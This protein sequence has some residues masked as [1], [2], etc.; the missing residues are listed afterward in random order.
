MGQDWYERC[1]R[2][3]GGYLKHWNST[4]EGE[5]GEVAFTRWLREAIPGHPRVLDAGCGDG[6]YTLH[7]AALAEQ[8]AG[9]DFAP[10]MIEA[11][12]RN[13]Q[14]AGITN[15]D[16][17][18]WNAR[19]GLPGG[20]GPFDL[21]FSRRGPTSHLAAARQVLAPGGLVAG[22][23]TGARDVIIPRLE[24]TGYRVV[25][26]EEYRGLEVFPSLE[27]FALFLS[28]VPGN[29]DFTLPEQRAELEARAAG[30]RTDRGYV[31]ERRWFIWVAA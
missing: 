28:R 2:R 6:L 25:R 31:V 1:A 30:A 23:H 11:A 9:F 26:N 13:Q 12:R 5:D 20:V 10:A 15:V 19:E 24:E 21:I 16:F 7:M 3:F 27:D 29:P 22:I 8:I 4:V 14:A 18:V 17:R